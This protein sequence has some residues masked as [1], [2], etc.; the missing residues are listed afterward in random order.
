MFRPEPGV[1][2]GTAANPSGGVLPSASE[3]AELEAALPAQPW[4][5]GGLLLG[6][7]TPKQPGAVA[8]PSGVAD[9][10]DLARQVGLALGVELTAVT[11]AHPALH[12][13]RT[14]EVRV[15]ETVI[16]VAGE[17]LPAIADELDL[18]RVVALLELD[19]DALL[20]AAPEQ[21]TA[22]PIGTLPAATQDLSLVVAAEIPAGDVLAAVREGAGELL[23]H[24]QLVDDYRGQGLPEGAKSLTFALRFRAPDRTLTAAEAT[25]AKL[26][27]AAL[28]TSR[29][30][31]TLRE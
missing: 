4:R 10:L 7:V 26:A 24:I 30:A 19:L 25:E 17:L 1:D 2:Y 5:V 3:L 28:A 18:P 8:A 11:G 21:V 16:G 6:D 13:G 9:A 31:A 23:E 14:A 20:A 29:H 22:Q 27:G 15:G 12:P